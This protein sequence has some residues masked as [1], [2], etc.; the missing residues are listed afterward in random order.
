M[1]DKGLNQRALSAVYTIVMTVP[2][3]SPFIIVAIMGSLGLDET[4]AGIF[5]TLEIAALSI[6]P[7]LLS[8]IAPHF[9]LKQILITGLTICLVG[10]FL[11]MFFESI[12]ILG[13][14][15]LCTGI[16]AGLLLLGVNKGISAEKDPVKLFGIVN[17]TALITAF[18]LFFFLPTLVDKYGLVGTYGLLTLLAAIALPLIMVMPQIAKVASTNTQ[19]SPINLSLTKILMLTTALVIIAAA[20]MTIYVF[21]EPIGV[22]SGYSRSEMG[23]LLALVQIAAISGASAATWVGLRWG[24]FRP[25]LFS[26]LGVAITALL[27]TVTQ[28]TTTFTIG[29][30]L[31]NFFFL[32]SLPYQLGLGAQIDHTGRLSSVCSGIFYLGI[33][34]SPFMGGYLISQHGQASLGYINCI[35]IA[36]GLTFFWIITRT[37]NSPVI[38]AQEKSNCA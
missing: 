25:L 13:T 16:G 35:A 1:E 31:L 24:A 21:A 28:S 26:L 37:M 15:R 22:A 20:Y 3:L 29:F 7:I 27:C 11:S 18:I 6:T 12:P 19:V 10:N 38:L 34:I 32:F 5:L 4:S 9:S 2:N 14:L 33:A 30:F 17:T 36:V 8:P 23:V